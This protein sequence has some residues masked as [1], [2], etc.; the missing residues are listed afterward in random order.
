MVMRY[1]RTLESKLKRKGSQEKL[2][3][4]KEDRRKCLK[5]THLIKGVTKTPVVGGQIDTCPLN[6][7]DLCSQ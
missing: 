1:L 3:G 4:E 5:A 7:S 2:T 6:K